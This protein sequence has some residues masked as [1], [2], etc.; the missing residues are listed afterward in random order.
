MD[1]T[2]DIHYSS[3]GQVGDVSKSLV[4]GRSIELIGR[5][6]RLVNLDWMSDHFFRAVNPYYK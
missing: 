2:L 1:R 5:W 4:R 6:A 3:S